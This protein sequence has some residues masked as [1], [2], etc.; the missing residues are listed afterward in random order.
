MR[1]Q[2]KDVWKLTEKKRKGLKS[3]YIKAKRR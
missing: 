3:V 2:R 1:K